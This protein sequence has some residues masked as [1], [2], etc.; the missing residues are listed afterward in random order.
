[1]ILEDDT[2]EYLSLYD[3]A[4]YYF[5]KQ[6]SN[7]Y[8]LTMLK[9]SIKKLPEEIE[10][11][12]IAL[13]TPYYDEKVKKTIDILY[14]KSDVKSFFENYLSKKK[15]YAEYRKE[16]SE[17]A[18]SHY[19]N[20]MISEEIVLGDKTDIFI[21]KK[22]AEK[23]RF[24]LLKIKGKLAWEVR[25]MAIEEHL[26]EQ[27]FLTLKEV[28]KIL[29]SSSITINKLI[30]AGII[31][32]VTFKGT[33]VFSKK[34]INQVLIK[35]Q[36]LI[37][38]YSKN[39]YTSEQIGEKY[40][41]S[42]QKYVKGSDEKIRFPITKVLP[43]LILTSYYGKALKLYKKIEI[44]RLWEDYN[45]FIKMN[46]VS[47]TNFY[48]DFIYKV[49]N[50]LSI[51]FNVNQQHTKVLWYEYVERF[52]INTKMQQKDRI[53]FQVNQFARCTEIIFGVFKKEIY[54]YT[55]KEINEKFLN[56]EMSIKRSYQRDFYTFLKKLDKA[57]QIEG[58]PLPYNFKDINDPRNFKRIKETDTGTYT[59][60]EYQN[61]YNHMYFAIEK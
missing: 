43:P 23:L 2:S 54:S 48:E 55:S 24:T 51:N 6:T 44:D 60:E 58:L 47:N 27:D 25:A 7:L 28:K 21:S 56:Q 32:E 41:P 61:L 40:N 31:K 22:L 29:N 18:V 38:E 5:G 19:Y 12:S 52:F 14:S 4:K 50:I 26:I 3:I 1:M 33:K 20:L 13:E 49:E 11:H 8:F 16:F 30:A 9:Q 15:I 39:Y 45:L 42:F 53:L 10:I 36:V 17:Y 59:L 57:F 34:E 35:Q 46:E 37:E